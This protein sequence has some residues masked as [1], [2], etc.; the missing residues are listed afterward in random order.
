M[1]VVKL[2]SLTLT[3]FKGIK[4]FQM[5]VDGKNVKVFGDNGVGKTTLFDAFWWILFDKDS[6][7]KKD[8]SIKTLDKDGNVIHN[9]EHVAELV[10]EVDGQ[11]IKLKKVFKEKWTKKRGQPT[12]EFTGHTTDYWID[13]VPIGRKSDYDKR[14]S[15]I[16]DEETFRLITSPTYFNEALKWQKRR[17]IL[18]QIAG[19]ITDEEVINS[20]AD[21]QKLND[22]LS[23]KSIE[24]FKKIIAAQKKE[25]N[26]QLDMIPVR[27]DELYRTIPE[28]E[29]I[30]ADELKVQLVKI[31]EQIDALKE[32]KLQ[33]QNGGAVIE[34]KQQLQELELKL[35]EYKRNFEYDTLQEV[36]KLQVRVQEAQSNLQITQNKLQ[37]EQHN[38]ETIQRSINELQQEKTRLSN[39]VNELREE[40]RRIN[41]EQAQY[42][43]KCPSCHQ[44]LP[45]EKIDEAIAN[46][47]LKKAHEL[48]AINEQ[49]QALK[50]QVAEI[51]KRIAAQTQLLDQATTNVQ[52]AQQDVAQKQKELDKAKTQLEKAQQSVPDVTQT[53]EYKSIIQQ[54]NTLENEIRQLQISVASEVIAI[55]EQINQLNLQKQSVNAQLGQLATVENNRKRIAELEEE[56]RRLA[57]EYEQLEHQTFLVEEFTRTKVDMLNERINSKF[58]Y[59]RFKLFEEQINGGLAEVCETTYNG[60]PYGSGLNNA[61][62][63]NV[64]LDIINTLC[65]HYGI[66]APIFIDNSESV[67]KLIESNSQLIQ[68]IVSEQDKTLR[69]EVE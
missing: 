54:K 66:Y 40:W 51:D 29:S 31:E 22:F 11:P 52:K 19:D 39:R 26:K 61:A 65:E 10:L 60:V 42:D 35:N 53:D 30:N 1:K 5:I 9:L 62:R 4:F 8:F 68:L 48:S 25:I 36:Y 32:K 67:T 46:F 38:T 50:E 59:A 13:D 63:I 43:D 58:K 6:Q 14:I 15:E 56:Q 47:N 28:D 69:V 21:L 23:G 41:D 7:N 34:K 55:D 64:G 45:Q 17:E 57:E 20:K 37:Q 3:N 24:D 27:I 44:P 2:L 49:G 16:I 33:V 18:M 12:P